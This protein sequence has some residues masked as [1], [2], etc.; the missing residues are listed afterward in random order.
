MEFKKF[1]KVKKLGDNEVKGITKG[2]CYVFPKLDGTN[3]SVWLGNDGRIHAGSRNQ[4]I[5]ASKHEDLSKNDNF[6]FYEYIKKQEDIKE[7]LQRYPELRL[8]GEWLVKHTLD[9]YRDDAWREFYIFDIATDKTEEEITHQGDDKVKY[10]H[11]EEYKPILEEFDLEYVP[12][13]AIVENG[14]KEKFINIM[15]NNKYLIKDGE[16]TGEGIVI[17]NY[18]FYNKYNRQPWAKLVSNKHKEQHKKEMGAPVKKGKTSIEEKIADEYVTEHKVDKVIA[19]VK[20]NHSGNW[21]SEYIP[22]LL[23]RCWHDLITEESWNIVQD[24]DR[25]TVDFGDLRYECNER[26]KELKPEVF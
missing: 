1:Q 9:T 19:K 2:T 18:E 16:G 25:P 10:L 6:G 4:E 14:G 13:L 15:K 23:G 26:V 24:F 17:K 5:P 21:Q 22:E 8:Y 11:Y 12:P 7:F 20:H 3:A